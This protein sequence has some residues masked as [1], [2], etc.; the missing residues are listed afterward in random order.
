M[1]IAVAILSGIIIFGGIR[2][3]ARVAEVIVPV[4]A[5][6]YLLLAIAVVIMNLSEI[7]GVLALIFSH[8]FGLQELSLIHI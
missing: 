7:P 5:G 3:I 2:Q 4:M 1:G 6:L 8:A